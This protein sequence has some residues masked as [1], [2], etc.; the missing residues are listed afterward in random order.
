MAGK[1]RIKKNNFTLKIE[2]LLIK[3]VIAGL[4]LLVGF[5]FIM[6]NDTARVFLN[7]TAGLEGSSFGADGM[8]TKEGR[9]YILL[10]NEML[11]PGVQLLVNGEPAASFNR[12][13]IELTV[14][15]NDLLE[16]DAA[17]V[18]DEYIHISVV[19]IS[20]NVLQPSVGLR[21]KAKSRIETI[22]RVRLK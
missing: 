2:K 6:L 1:D 14:R 13:E 18:N 16:L 3:A 21:V 8:L 4:I 19:G 12:R 7:Y 9:I 5:Q 17:R 11:M 15:N 10:E 22:S 20:D